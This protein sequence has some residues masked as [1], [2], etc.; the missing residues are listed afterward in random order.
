[1]SPAFLFRAFAAAEGQLGEGVTWRLHRSLTFWAGL[2]VMA[3]LLWGW[4]DSMRHLTVLRHSDHAMISAGGGLTVSRWDGFWMTGSGFVFEHGTFE[5]NSESLREVGLRWPIYLR[6]SGPVWQERMMTHFLLPGDGKP[7]DP[8]T[9]LLLAP[10]MGGQ[11]D[12]MLY[13]PYWLLVLVLPLPW[14]AM[15]VWRW[16]RISRAGA[17]VMEGGEG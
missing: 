8:L 11:G 17:V 14:G 4:W 12:W 7:E 16:Q 2:L 1:M 10:V 3:S 13:L 5:G 15:L 9:P 6:N